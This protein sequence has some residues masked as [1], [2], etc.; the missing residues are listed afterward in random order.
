MLRAAALGPVSASR[1]QHVVVEQR[2]RRAVAARQRDGDQGYPPRTRIQVPAIAGRE[3]PRPWRLCAGHRASVCG[4][5]ASVCGAPRGGRGV[6]ARAGSGPDALRYGNAADS[7]ASGE[8]GTAPVP[9]GSGRL[10]QR[11]E[12]LVHTEEVT[13]SIPVSPT[14]LRGRLRSCNRP[15]L[16]PVQHRST[17]T[18]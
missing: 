9:S 13:G 6:C 10:A 8:P 11:G 16:L 4:H 3:V 5:R 17:A 14:H 12:R 15:F 18:S 2:V 7:R 1:P